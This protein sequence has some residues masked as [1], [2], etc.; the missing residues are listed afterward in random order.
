MLFLR[1]NGIFRPHLYLPAAEPIV[2]FPFNDE[3]VTVKHL[4]HSIIHVNHGAEFTNGVGGEGVYLRFT[5]L[6]LTCDMLFGFD[7]TLWVFK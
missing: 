5:I 3:P 1:W 7:F 4:L 2:K 6:L